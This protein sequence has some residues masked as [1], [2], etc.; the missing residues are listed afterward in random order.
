MNLINFISQYPDEASCKAK[1][2]AYRDREG[3]IFPDCGHN[4][5][6]WKKDK[7]CYE[8]Q[9]MQKTS[10]FTPIPSCMV[11]PIALSLLVFI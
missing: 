1:C 3:I 11:L 8:C 9:A 2:K 7:E 6:Y 5:H 4:E 10:E